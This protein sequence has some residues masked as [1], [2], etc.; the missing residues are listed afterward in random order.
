MLVERSR[1]RACRSCARS[2]PI[3]P[4]GSRAKSYDGAATA[5][6]RRTAE[7]AARS[8]RRGG[9]DAVA[10][11]RLTRR[12]VKRRVVAV[13]DRD[14][15]VSVAPVD[16]DPVEVDAAE[17]RDLAAAQRDEV[18]AV[19]RALDDV[20]DARTSRCSTAPR[21]RRRERSANPRSSVTTVARD[22]SRT[23]ERRVDGIEAR[24]LRIAGDG[25]AAIPETP[26][27]RTR[28]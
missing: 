24:L 8:P 7:T 2:R 15:H 1:R 21:P 26:R 20:A 11:E 16:R 25:R 23:L 6:L 5:A 13:Q 14:P 10:C 28:R 3:A 22:R 17:A 27:A 12:S 18:V 19:V 4:A 9:A